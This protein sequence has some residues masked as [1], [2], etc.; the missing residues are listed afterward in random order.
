MIACHADRILGSHSTFNVSTLDTQTS[1]PL[2]GG[3]IDCRNRNRQPCMQRPFCSCPSS[4]L[5]KTNS[6]SNDWEDD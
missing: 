2:P 4:Q 1:Q 5:V 6:L 3:R